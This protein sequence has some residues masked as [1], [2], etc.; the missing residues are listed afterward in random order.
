MPIP[1]REPHTTGSLS[2]VSNM[3]RSPRL[4]DI[5]MLATVKRNESD[6]DQRGNSS[7]LAPVILLI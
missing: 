5:A 1:S 3:I 6:L 4:A 2:I 7:Y